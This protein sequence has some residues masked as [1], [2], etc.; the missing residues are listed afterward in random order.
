MRRSHLTTVFSA[1]L[2][3]VRALRPRQHHSS[4]RHVVFRLFAKR[5]A[6]WARGACRVKAESAC[7]VVLWSCSVVEL[8]RHLPEVARGHV[9]SLFFYLVCKDLHG[10]FSLSPVRYCMYL[11]STVAVH[12]RVLVCPQGSE[13]GNSRAYETVL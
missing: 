7:V 1:H 12:G 8:V 5:G 3:I 13:R 10:L 2:L 6:L 11:V 4:V 9:R